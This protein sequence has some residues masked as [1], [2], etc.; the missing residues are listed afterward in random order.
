MWV[1]L[2]SVSG[3]SAAVLSPS[4]EEIAKAAADGRRLAAPHEGY[5]LKDYVVYE[6]K[7]ARAIDPND[8]DVDAVVIATPLERTRHAAFV[9][10]F[11]GHRIGSAEAR[12]R[13][14][15]PDNHIEIIIFAHGADRADR[16]F[17]HGFGPAFLIQRTQPLAAAL[18]V[19][20]A[21][22]G[23]VYPLAQRDRRRFVATIS[24]RFDLSSVPELAAA[25]ARVTFR[26]ASG[27]A[28]DLPVDLSAYR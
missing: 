3:A 24:Y 22:F 23:A 1:V 12:A 15:L 25:K 20:D 26:D 17:V 5:P 19:A 9:A 14:L 21:P 7:D 11:A 4:T 28:F 10:A 6:V 8:S 27:K 2:T 18:P 16:R 13:S